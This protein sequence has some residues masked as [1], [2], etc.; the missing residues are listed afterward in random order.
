MG[1]ASM[2]Y[3]LLFTDTPLNLLPTQM[4]G[5]IN[6]YT[7]L[8]IPFFILAGELM[9]K[10][11]VTLRLVNFTKFF[12]GHLKGGLAYTSVGVNVFAAGVSGSAPADCSAVSSV[13]LPAMK[14]E[15]YRESFSAAINAAAS[16]I[17]PIIPP[18]IPMIFLALLTNL[19]VGR[20]FLG[21]VIPGLLMGV[22]LVV[23]LYFLMRNQDLPVT[24][25]ER[26]WNLF[27]V[28]LKDA[29]LSLIAPLIIIAGVLTG[30]VTVTEV[31][32]LAAGYVLFIGMFIYRTI[33]PKDLIGIFAN[34]ALFS[35]TILVLFSIVGIF[36]WIMASE[37]IGLKLAEG[38]IALDLGP[39]AFLLL[40]NIFLLFIG[41]IMDALPAML[42]FVPVLLPLSMELGIDPI[43]FGMIVVL[44]LMI[45]L[46][47]PPVGG[48]LYIVSKI[49]NVPFQ[50]VSKS[51]IP[52][53]FALIV[54]L[55]IVTYVPA[56]V[57]WLPNLLMG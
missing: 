2:V 21:G 48:L 19:S 33:K 45:G 9:N 25:V 49:G 35:A 53:V 28:M 22:G 52:F 32:I 37:Q 39:V 46:I 16:T 6:N 20:L 4:V 40:V 51:I 17:G 56:L 14:K 50:H 29:I 31:S 54:V 13:M 55:M 11:G 57:T 3:L 12:I 26:N 15:G 1:V 30:I 23:I 5:G 10:S 27:F 43:H 36:S 38:F 42:I 47:T 41:M 44:N 8:A 34:T 18:S 7:L 24:K